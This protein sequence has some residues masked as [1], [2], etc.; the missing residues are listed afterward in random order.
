M[1][2]TLKTEYPLV[3][4]HGMFGWGQNEGINKKAPYWGATTGNL[5]DYLSGLGV[6][7]YAASVGPMS[8]AWDQACEL[9]AQLTGTRVDYGEAHSKKHGHKRFGRTYGKPLFPDWSKDKKV[10]LIGHSFGG[11]AI[12]MLTHLLTYGSPEEKEMSGDNVSP[13]FIGGKEELVCSVTAICSPLNGTDAYETARKHKLIPPLKY[14]SYNYAGVIS[15]SPL[16]GKFADFH[17]EQFGLSDTPG[18]KDREP[19]VKSVRALFDT[20]DC[21]AYDMSEQGA[22]DMND[23]IRISPSVY[24]FSY[25]FNAL[26][27][28]KKGK[29]NRPVNTDFI[30]MKA[31]SALMLHDNKKSGKIT[32]GN[33]GLVDVDSA[34]FPKSEPFVEF[35]NSGKL[36]AGV[37][38]VM[39]TGCG[40]HGT[41]IG[42]FADKSET[43]SLYLELVSILSKAENNK[44]A[45]EAVSKEQSL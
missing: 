24:Y 17:L 21:I 10:H 22:K 19:F 43:H 15:R 8:S 36:K 13:L 2:E 29:E 23:L 32:A 5:T 3:F 37:W 14:I 1:P 44:A 39:P 30:L 41:P 35:E 38:N 40:D 31:T 27:K 6:E 4:V 34:R 45:K 12:R 33:D 7:C 42:L 26:G 16:S 25:Q 28:T 11:N 9:Y 20:K 18:S